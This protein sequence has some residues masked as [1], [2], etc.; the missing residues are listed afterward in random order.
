MYLTIEMLLLLLIG[1]NFVLNFLWRGPKAFIRSRSI[2][3]VSV[4]T[5]TLHSMIV[6]MSAAIIVHYTDTGVVCDVHGGLGNT[7]QKPAS[8]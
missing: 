1:F 6:V 8:F 3:I 5:E 7:E 4:Y 2:L